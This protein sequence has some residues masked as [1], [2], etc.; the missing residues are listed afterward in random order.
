MGQQLMAVVAEAHRGRSTSPR[1]KNMSPLQRKRSPEWGPDQELA[2]Y[3]LAGPFAPMLRLGLH[4]ADL[5]T[6]RQLVALTTFSDLVGEAQERG[7]EGC[8]W[9]PASRRRRAARTMVARVRKPMRMRWR[10][11]WLCCR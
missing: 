7:A 10:H 3:I 6:P 1:P 8:A 11:I 5:F 4:Y 2:G 9:L